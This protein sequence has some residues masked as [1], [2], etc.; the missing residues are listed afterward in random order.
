MDREL[1]NRLKRLRR[2]AEKIGC[3]INKERGSDSFILY[4]LA[5]KYLILRAGELD[6]I[7]ERI[8]WEEAGE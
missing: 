5:N 6:E 1:E 3:G 4:D 2:R 8:T 7:E